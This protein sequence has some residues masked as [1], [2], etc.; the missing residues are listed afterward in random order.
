MQQVNKTDVEQFNCIFGSQVD[1]LGQQPSDSFEDR[2]AVQI[3]QIRSINYVL[4]VMENGHL[5]LGL[6]LL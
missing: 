5:E 3:L 1:P 2:G 6:V 4:S